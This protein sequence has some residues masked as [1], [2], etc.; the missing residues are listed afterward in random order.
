VGRDAE[1]AVPRPVNLPLVLLKFVN[2]ETLVRYWQHVY[3]HCRGR[4]TAEELTYI[5]E[6]ERGKIVVRARIY[7]LIYASVVALSITTRSILPLMY[8]GLPS[9]FGTWLMVIYGLTQHAGLAENVLDHRL[10]TRTVCMNAIHRYLYWNMGYHVEHHMFP[11]VPYH[12]L[13]ELHEL[14]QADTPTPYHGLIEAWREIIPTLL[15]ESKDPTYYV[16]RELPAPAQGLDAVHAAPAITAEAGPIGAG[17][18]VVCAGDRL[19]KEDVIRFDHDNKTYAIY[20]TADDKVYATDGLCTHARA[21]L[22][23]GLVTGNLIE[24]PKHNARF[25]VRDGSPQR[26]PARIPLETYD[27]RESDGKIMLK[28]TS[29]TGQA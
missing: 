3:L 25:D 16:K 27:V 29:R 5:P 20:R 17:W 23:D 8:I 26:L 19:H 2:G 6:T 9:F 4:L 15:R 12:A 1:I 28:P 14:I 7:V 13:P 18:I 21:Q 11:M 10:N 22:A 24:C